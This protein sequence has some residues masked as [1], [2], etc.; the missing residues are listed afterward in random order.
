MYH[1][2]AFWIYSPGMTLGCIFFIKMKA[3]ELLENESLD[4][5]VMI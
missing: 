4:F 5:L 1:M 3:G 2:Y